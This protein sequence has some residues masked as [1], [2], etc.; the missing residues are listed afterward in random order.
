MPTSSGRMRVGTEG[1]RD[2]FLNRLFEKLPAWV[3]LL[4]FFAKSGGVYIKRAIMFLCRVEEFFIKR[5]AISIW[6]VTKL[7]WQ[8]SVADDFKQA[9]LSRRGE[10]FKI[11][12][13]DFPNVARFPFGKLVRTVHGP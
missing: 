5:S 6:P 4:A 1:D 12:G 3:N 7:F 2:A 10:P 11:H 9:G 13:P 8:I